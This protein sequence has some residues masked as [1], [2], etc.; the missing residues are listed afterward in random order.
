M[1]MV[2]AGL[3]RA[4]ALWLT[5]D[6]V[7]DM[8]YLSVVTRYDA[9]NDEDDE[10]GLEIGALKTEG[11]TRTVTI[12]PPLRKFLEQYLP[13]LKGDWL[14]PNPWKEGER[15]EPDNF[16][17]ALRKLNAR[18]G[19]KWSSL[20]FRHTYATCRCAEGW[21]VFD[22]AS[23]MGT[24]IAMIQRHYAGFIKPAMLQHCAISGPHNEPK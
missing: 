13:T 20:H 18:N 14:V 2:H 3:R 16:S 12:L 11:S 1:L 22:L 7:K 6:S 17:A 15:W 21:P 5:R 8:S 19:L 10:D 24:S 23:E 4:E 9:E